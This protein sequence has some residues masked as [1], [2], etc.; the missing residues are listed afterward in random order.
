MS[1]GFET[2]RRASASPTRSEPTRSRSPSPA[3][4]AARS[5]TPRSL[6]EPEFLSVG[7]TGADL[8][9]AGPSREPAP[10]RGLETTASNEAG[11]SAHTVRRSARDPTSPAP[12]EELPAQL[13]AQVAEEPRPSPLALRNLQ[14]RWEAPA[15]LSGDALRLAPAASESEASEEAEERERQEYAARQAARSAFADFVHVA[16][17]AQREFATRARGTTQALENSYERATTSAAM[18]FRRHLGETSNAATGARSAIQ[19]AGSEAQSGLAAA[20]QSAETA[21]MSAGRAALAGIDKNDRATEDRIERVVLDL[22]RGHQ[23]V[24]QA[25][26]QRIR[27][28]GGEAVGALEAWRDR[29]S[30]DHPVTGRDDLEN[31]QNEE[32]L[33][34][35]PQIVQRDADD[36]DGRVERKAQE[37]QSSRDTT[38]CSLS[39]S[40]QHALDTQR[41]EGK[42]LAVKAIW[43]TLGR[44]R[45]ALR[46]QSKSGAATLAQQVSTYLGQVDAQEASFRSRLTSRLHQALVR[47]YRTAQSAGDGAHETAQSALPMFSR[48]ALELESALR[49]AASGGIDALLRATESA[50][51]PLRSR[52]ERARQRA[53]SGLE[54][55]H[56]STQQQLTVTGHE[57]DQSSATDA[58]RAVAVQADLEAQ[59]GER[60]K[61]SVEKL[62][63]SFDG[64]SSGVTTAGTKWV[65]DLNTRLEET[66]REKRA[67]ASRK[68]KELETGRKVQDSSPTPPPN[69]RSPSSEKRPA[70]DCSSCEQPKEAAKQ[71][72]AQQPSGRTRASEGPQ[73]LNAQRDRLLTIVNRRTDPKSLFKAALDQIDTQVYKK[74]RDRATKVIGALEHGVIDKV[75]EKGV[76]AALRGLSY[77]GGRAL[78]RV[79]YPRMVGEEPWNQPSLDSTLRRRLRDALD[80]PSDDYA[81]A[82]AYLF[83]DRVRGAR[84]ELSLSVGFFNDD[85]KR[86]E[87]VMRALSP[88]ELRSLARDPTLEEEIGSKLGGTDRKVFDALRRGD[89]ALADA[90]RMRDAVDRARRQGKDDAVHKAIEQYTGALAEGDW[91]QTQLK[92]QDRR[93]G[94]VEALGKVL[95]E[96]DAAR[97]RTAGSKGKPDAVDRA[98]Q[99]VTRDIEVVVSGGHGGAHTTTRKITGANLDLAEALLRHGEGSLDVRVARLGVELQRRGRVDMTNLDR[100]VFDKR[101]EPDSPDATPKQKRENAK[102]REEARVDRARILTR[103]AAKYLP[104]GSQA[105]SKDPNAVPSKGEIATA[106]AALTER[107]RKRFGSDETGAQLAAGLLRDERPSAETASLAM[108]YGMYSRAGTDE[109]WLKRFVGRMTSKEIEAMRGQFRKD[110]GD[111]LDAELGIY[112]EGTFGELSG[113]DRL[114]MERLMLGIAQTDADR[115]RHAAFALQ[116]QRR[117][118][119]WAGELFASD[120]LAERA[121]TTAEADLE[122]MVGGAIKLDRRGGLEATLKNFGDQGQY[123]GADRAAF[124]ATTDTAQQIADNYGARIGAFGDFVVTGIEV[125]GAVAA[126]VLTGGAAGPLIIAGLATGLTSMAANAAIR[127]GRYGWEQ[128]G[129]DLGMTAFQAATAGVGAKL[130]QAAKE[131]GT[132]SKLAKTAKTTEAAANAAKAA[133]QARATLGGLGRILTGNPVADDIIIG[134]LTGSAGGLVNRAVDER[135][136]EKG[137]GAAFGALLSG[138]LEGTLSGGVSSGLTSQIES[139]ARAGAAIRA[140]ALAYANQG[141]HVRRLVGRAG[142]GVGRAGESFHSALE[143]TTGGGVR[144]SLGSMTRRGLAKGTVSSLGAMAG[145]GTE[146][147][148]QAATDRYHGDAGDVFSDLGGVGLKGFVQ[149]VGEGA[150][151]AHVEGR[152]AKREAAAGSEAEPEVD[153]APEPSADDDVLQ[154]PAFDD[155]AKPS[156]GAPPEAARGAAGGEGGDGGQGGEPPAPP[157]GAEPSRRK[158]ESFHDLSD[159][160]ISRALD[161]GPAEM[162]SGPF[163]KIGADQLG[164]DVQPLPAGTQARMRQRQRAA[165]LRAEADQLSRKAYAELDRA[166]DHDERAKIA[167]TYDRDRARRL[168]TAANK[169]LDA[170]VELERRAHA[171]RTEADEFASGR[172][173]AVDDLPGPADVDAMLAAARADDPGL[174]A[175]PLDE[176]H[177]KPE[178]LRR[179][180]RPLLRGERG[181]RLV[182]RVESARS[183]SLVHVDSNGN[184]RIQEGAVVHLNGGSLERA[185]EFIFQNSQ[186]EVRLIA[187]EVDEA[188]WRSLRSTAAPEHRAAAGDHQQLVDVRAA[189]DQIAVRGRTDETG[190]LQRPD[191]PSQID[192]LTRMIVPGTGVVHE[193]PAVNPIEAGADG[194]PAPPAGEEPPRRRSATSAEEGP[195]PLHRLTAEEIDRAVD[196]DPDQMGAEALARTPLSRSA[197]RETILDLDAPENVHL[198]D[199]MVAQL[200]GDFA[201]DHAASVALYEDFIAAHPELESA[202]L[203]NRET[204]EYV[205]VQGDAERVQFARLNDAWAELSPELAGRGRWVGV[206]HSHPVDPR[207]GLTPEYARLPSGGNGD[208]MGVVTEALHVGRR[209]EEEIR[210]RTERGDDRVFFAYDPNSDHPYQINIADA[211]GNR[212]PHRFETIEDYHEWALAH[213]NSN[214]GDIPDDFPGRRRFHE[215]DDEPTQPFATLPDTV[216]DTVEDTLVSRRETTRRSAPASP[217]EVAA[218]VKAERSRI[219]REHRR[220]RKHGDDEFVRQTQ[221]VRDLMTQLMKRLRA[222][223]QVQTDH[224]REL[225]QALAELPV[226]RTRYRREDTDWFETLGRNLRIGHATDSHGIARDAGVPE[227]LGGYVVT[228]RDYS[229]VPDQRSAGRQGRA[230][231]EGR[232]P[233]RERE[234]RYWGGGAAVTRDPIVAD[235]GDG[236]SSACPRGYPGSRDRSYE[237]PCR[238]GGPPG[239]RQVVAAERRGGGRHRPAD[240]SRGRPREHSRGP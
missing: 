154:S 200:P 34:R 231:R 25:A 57:H 94:V 136:W 177:D 186:G 17:R 91:R 68:L 51:P 158:R 58:G 220:A 53:E 153:S 222:G 97:G 12:S 22:V 112:D 178:L 106:R 7:G 20:T 104:D 155:D 27:K 132:A 140:R 75:D 2:S 203:H 83:G 93:R 87:Q 152:K 139:F 194:R 169:I 199:E 240:S 125:V 114:E 196:V 89:H 191:K 110:T 146:L 207:T 65:Q 101:F 195:D 116:Q 151:E 213:A 141:G 82:S 52:T 121:L 102:R 14:V 59:A 189:D 217:D 239:R 171:L 137:P 162:D 67:D 170:A 218:K 50:P 163:F 44:A 148:Y 150:A 32:R 183:R 214:V 64:L 47:L 224:L 99:Y 202:L 180:V 36:V 129:I 70:P 126:I 160:E 211:E 28:A 3:S 228:R 235:G 138:L 166:I 201:R 80:A 229:Q 48:S 237:G 209:F 29:R 40:Y 117:E 164:A 26:I 205:V 219:Y 215:F 41:E 156:D 184:V 30:R 13:V 181:G 113:D 223:E 204:G 128:A 115:A 111:D 43:K 145:R 120:S 119:G 23:D 86:I 81:V 105:S 95:L 193:H 192:E 227:D 24:Y 168:R 31:A 88:G 10:A 130:G 4:K 187:F 79:V 225:E 172:R 90:H 134:V 161:T 61:A 197:A 216:E 18:T 131:L 84:L 144:Q 174:V 179:L 38:V 16:Q 118:A 182:F 122:R 6:D 236:R 157:G 98:V 11:S 37:W 208:F 49:T 188:W 108:Q 175:I 167:D 33:R 124:L 76:L 221:P 5:S 185:M 230:E 149:G 210:I 35:I 234:A 56:A 69:G 63:S 176:V 100:A 60:L 198:Q 206:S 142:A 226:A 190:E 212:V 165:S 232:Q 159:A 133:N 15:G 72:P 42:G 66:I 107:F 103:A 55:S 1:P 127:G 54:R 173:S 71:G 19:R 233:R 92:P 74:L 143:A 45:G 147:A 96:E 85:E 46:R 21:I 62:E 78:D 135:T 39:C 9:T 8:E 73:G 123:T 238:R 109:A 77:L